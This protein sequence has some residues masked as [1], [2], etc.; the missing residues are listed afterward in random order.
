MRKNY[1]AIVNPRGRIDIYNHIGD[2]IEED[3]CLDYKLSATPRM[4]PTIEVKYEILF[5][6]NESEL[7]EKTKLEKEYLIETL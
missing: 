3:G 4:I 2:K 6:K 1:Y 5:L 7:Q